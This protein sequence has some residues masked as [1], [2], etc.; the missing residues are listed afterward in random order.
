MEVNTSSTQ[1]IEAGNITEDSKASSLSGATRPLNVT[2]A[3]SYLDTVKR[4]FVEHPNVY[5]EFLDIMKDFKRQVYASWPYPSP[6]ADFALRIDTPG[7]IERVLTLFKG[8]PSLILGFNLFLPQ[9]YRIDC[10]GDDM[11]TITVITPYG[12]HTPTSEGLIPRPPGV[13]NADTYLANQGSGGYQNIPG[14]VFHDQDPA[15]GPPTLPPF[16]HP[17]S[18]TV[19]D[20]PHPPTHRGFTSS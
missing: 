16:P 1:P 6:S 15:P 18:M 12:T 2:D 20:F 5:N 17:S 10:G 3:L 7:V 4:K 8:F 13:S 14:E 9:G 11:N 19:P